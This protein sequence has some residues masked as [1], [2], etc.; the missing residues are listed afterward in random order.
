MFGVTQAKINEVLYD[1]FVVTDSSGNLITG[2]VDG[3]F[4]RDLYNPSG[5]EVS[6]TVTVTITELGNGKYRVSFTPNE[7]GNWILTVY[8]AT[9]FSY[10]KSANYNVMEYL[11][12]DAGDAVWDSKLVDYKSGTTFGYKV[13]H[14][15]G[16]SKTLKEIWTKQEKDQLI[17]AMNNLITHIKTTQTQTF[18]EQVKARDSEIYKL[19]EDKFEA[20]I[21][22]LVEFINSLKKDNEKTIEFINN[23]KGLE[24][25]D[26]HKISAELSEKFTSFASETTQ[27]VGQMNSDAKILKEELSSKTTEFIDKIESNREIID[28][29]CQT[30]SEHIQGLD[31]NIIDLAKIV[32]KSLSAKQIEE[33]MKEEG[34]Y[35]LKGTDKE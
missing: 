14:I 28:K 9:Y 12:G 34:L 22:T 19:V 4:T 26:I 8:N 3:N 6:G 17:E 29:V 23:A 25:D 30:N 18:S 1:E 5:S 7:L 15:T 35:D 20:R 10:G 13:Q 11:P 24:L 33:L 27:L 32:L 16:A 21:N 31:K 2:L